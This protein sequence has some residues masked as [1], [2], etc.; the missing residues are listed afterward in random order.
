[1]HEPLLLQVLAQV[2]GVG[3]SVSE[4]TVTPVQVMWQPLPVQDVL[5]FPTLPQVT[6]QPPPAQEKRQ[7]PVSPQ[8]KVQPPPGQSYSQLPT[9]LQEQLVPWGQVPL[10]F[11]TVV[12]LPQPVAATQIAKRHASSTP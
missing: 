3:Q 1:V 4:Q 7:L 11:P 8:V 2:E 5:Q 10:K 6:L 9:T 12:E